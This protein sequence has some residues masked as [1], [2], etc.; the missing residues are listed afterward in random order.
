MQG[1]TILV[2][3]DNALIALD[4]ADAL[5]DQGALVIGPATRVKDGLDLLNENAVD[6][7]LLDVDLLDGLVT[8][9][10]EALLAENIPVIFCTGTQIPETL[11]ANHPDLPVHYKPCPTDKLVRELADLLDKA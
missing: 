5:E 10:A 4:L 9:I 8:P 6:A 1:R 3:E 11:K 7:A 2:A